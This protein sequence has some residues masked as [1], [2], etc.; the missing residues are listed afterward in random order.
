MN[1]VDFGILFEKSLETAA[2]NAEEKTGRYV[3]RQFEIELH[4]AGHSKS[5][6]TVQQAFEALYLWRRSV[7]QDR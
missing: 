5:L 2:Q 4:G 7:L 1:K 3:P 6:V